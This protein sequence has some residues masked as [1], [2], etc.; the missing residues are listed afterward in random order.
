MSEGTFSR[1]TAL[2][3]SA[4][5][6]KMITLSKKLKQGTTPVKKEEESKRIS[7]RDKL[8]VKGNVTIY[9]I[10]PT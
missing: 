2:L 1:I 9:H 3:F 4:E 8:L 10:Y 5:Q 7:V 6:D